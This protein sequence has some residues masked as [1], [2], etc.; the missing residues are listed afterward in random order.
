MDVRISIPSGMVLTDSR[1][2]CL[3]T[4]R[5]VR[6]K[7]LLSTPYFYYYNNNG[8]G[9]GKSR[10]R[11]GRGKPEKLVLCVGIMETHPSSSSWIESSSL[12]TSSVLTTSLSQTSYLCAAAVGPPVALASLSSMLSSLAS[13]SAGMAFCQAAHVKVLSCELN[14]GQCLCL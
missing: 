11:S 3:L 1:P 2:C 12:Y 10:S 13:S 14:G 7:Y 6:T 9:S 8:G 4:P 5:N